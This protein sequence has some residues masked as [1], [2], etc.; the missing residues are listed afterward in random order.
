MLPPTGQN[1]YSLRS[2]CYAHVDHPAEF[3]GGVPIHSEEGRRQAAMHY[4]LLSRIGEDGRQHHH[5]IDV[6]FTEQS[7]IERHGFYD[8]EPP[9]AVLAR[10]GLTPSAIESVF[11][12]HMHF[13]HMNALRSFPQA[14]VYV[15]RS[16]YEFWREVI[17]LPERFFPL[18][19]ESFLISSFHA[20]DLGLVEQLAA[21]GRLHFVEDGVELLPGVHGHLS[22]GGHSFGLQW[23][24][25]E[26]G[27]GR[28]AI[29][30]DAAM[31]YSNLEEMWPSGYTGG[32]TYVMVRTY[33]DLLEAVDGDLG[34]IVPGH[35]MRI[36][37]NFPSWRQGR[38]EVAEVYLA[39]WDQGSGD[40]GAV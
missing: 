7:W 17:A 13:D 27:G 14:E 26:T 11:L 37:E 15:Q 32:S 25:V 29:A 19:R 28:Y 16:E 9:E 12:T 5:L 23:L 36:Y 33:G 1:D 30:S 3:F 24:S 6:G 8:W 4:V 10:V 20:D 35:D 2:L 34:R 39:P 31:W 18:G 22:R 21:A 38:G 40:R